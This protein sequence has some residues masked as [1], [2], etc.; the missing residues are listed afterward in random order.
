MYINWLVLL[1]RR[2]YRNSLRRVISYL[3]MEEGMV[4]TRQAREALQA[5]LAG[6]LGLLVLRRCTT[7]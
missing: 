7:R 5:G 6:T 1:E 3:R 2:I 4:E